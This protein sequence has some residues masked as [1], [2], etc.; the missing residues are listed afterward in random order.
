MR[1]L[2]QQT[3][4]EQYLDGELTPTEQVKVEE[5]LA[6]DPRFLREVIA[7]QTL[8]AEL[9]AVPHPEIPG[10][11]KAFDAHVMA[12][13][14]PHALP[15]SA[16][17]FDAP[18]LAALFPA[19]S[20]SRLL[21][22]VAARLYLALSLL[23]GVVGASLGAVLLQPSD[24]ESATATGLS[25]HVQGILGGFASVG[26][27]LIDGVVSFTG[28]LTPLLATLRPVV[29]GI[30]SLV[31]SAAPAV[32]LPGLFVI[33]IAALVLGVTTGKIRGKGLPHGALS[34]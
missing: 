23:F 5:L 4:L 33:L 15:V 31:A 11:A 9:A 32:L 17:A 6:G 28:V 3:L 7:H 16:H 13:V 8:F 22:G 20:R 21:V 29:D 18:I 34:L 24:V 25:R 2:N 10:G 26:D 19:L 14:F 1:R 30:S 12:Q 27:R